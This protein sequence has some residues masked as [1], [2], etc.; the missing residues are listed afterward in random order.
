MY[1]HAHVNTLGE[2]RWMEIQ[3]IQFGMSQAY[4]RTSKIVIYSK[5]LKKQSYRIEKHPHR[6]DDFCH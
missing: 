1:T 5:Q 4:G 6:N 3:L 2:G